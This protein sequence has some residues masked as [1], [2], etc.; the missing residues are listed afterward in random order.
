[1]HK[2]NLSKLIISFV[3]FNKSAWKEMVHS[4]VDANQWECNLFLR[5]WQREY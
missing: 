5:N 2:N 1:M 4:L 3:Y